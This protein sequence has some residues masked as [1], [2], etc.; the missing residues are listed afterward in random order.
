[1]GVVL[2]VANTFSGGHPGAE[3]NDMYRGMLH[4]IRPVI[5]E[6]FRIFGFGLELACN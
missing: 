2:L 4:E 5:K 6:H 3:N 1:V